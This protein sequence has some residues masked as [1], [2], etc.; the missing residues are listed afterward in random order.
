MSSSSLLLPRGGARVPRCCRPCSPGVPAGQAQDPRSGPVWSV[1]GRPREA[2]TCF[3]PL[4]TG[5]GAMEPTARPSRLMLGQ[6]AAPRR[7]ARRFWGVPES[8]HSWAPGKAFVRGGRAPRASSRRTRPL[9]AD[10]RGGDIEQQGPGQA[11]PHSVP[12][13]WTPWALPASTPLSVPLLMLP[14]RTK[15]PRYPSDRQESRLL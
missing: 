14:S 7:R 1:E 4:G 12:V 11:P 3:C 5:S 6:G 2:S 10:D 13:T 9:G 8:P 15:V